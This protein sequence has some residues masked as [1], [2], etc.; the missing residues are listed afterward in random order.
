MSEILKAIPYFGVAVGVVIG[1]TIAAYIGEALLIG[2]PDL[3][4][5]FGV[6]ILAAT[7]AWI[8]LLVCPPC[9]RR[10]GVGTADNE[11]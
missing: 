2:A 8:T 3:A 9:R 10:L 5:D 1:G 6:G 11:K 7:I 4:F